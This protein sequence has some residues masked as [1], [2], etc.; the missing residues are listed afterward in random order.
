LLR[1]HPQIREIKEINGMGQL[2]TE[3]LYSTAD[4]NKA[5]INGLECA[6]VVLEKAIDLSYDGQ[7]VMIKSLKKIVHR[8]K[9]RAVMRK[10]Q[11]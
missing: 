3:R 2:S 7:R 10:L 8:H 4:L 11:L 1:T 6:V 9:I 5:Y